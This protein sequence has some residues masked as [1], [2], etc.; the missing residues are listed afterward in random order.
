[1]RKYILTEY[2]DI[3]G[4][5]GG[6]SSQMKGNKYYQNHLRALELMQQE[7]QQLKED[8]KTK[9]LAQAAYMEYNDDFDEE[10][11]YLTAAEK[12]RRREAVDAKEGRAKSE[13]N[14]NSKSKGREKEKDGM[15][16]QIE[17]ISEITE[18][19]QDEFFFDDEDEDD[20][21]DE[22]AR[23]VEGQDQELTKERSGIL[24]DEDDVGRK[25]AL[26]KKQ[27]I[28][29]LEQDLRD[30]YQG[31]TARQRREIEE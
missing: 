5:A 14:Q 21:L 11:L 30:P 8:V 25:K 23:F 29:D 31:M 19:K 27:L 1:M 18:K 13:K 12:Q 24:E 10:D 7:E 9:I 20:M 16:Q 6:A 17:E 2:S 28:K 22:M 3:L 26:R 15:D 4:P